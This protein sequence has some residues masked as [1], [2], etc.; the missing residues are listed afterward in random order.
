MTRQGGGKGTNVATAFARLG[1]ATE[2]VGAVG[3]DDFGA[4]AH[5]RLE[6]DG[7]GVFELRTLAGVATGTAMIAVDA[8]GED[9]SW[10]GLAPTRR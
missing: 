2:F 3:D 7:V 1:A 9:R 4:R 8:R 5:A 6:A 10:S